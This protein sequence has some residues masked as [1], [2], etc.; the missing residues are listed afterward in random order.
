MY[1]I[2]DNIVHQDCRSLTESVQYLCI[3]TV[4]RVRVA[5]Q[6]YER[7]VFGLK[8]QNINR[9]KWPEVKRVFII[10]TLINLHNKPDSDKNNTN[11]KP[12]SFHVQINQR[13]TKRKSAPA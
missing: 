8:T 6:E 10:I 12:P 4:F 3:F 9:L 7:V 2:C 11:R 1:Q 13:M 5:N